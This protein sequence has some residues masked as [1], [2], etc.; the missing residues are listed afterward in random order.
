MTV[1]KVSAILGVITGL[2]VAGWVM[3]QDDQGF[4]ALLKDITQPAES[5]P[6]PEPPGP[7]RLPLGVRLDYR[8]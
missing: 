2:A 1:S 7:A 8:R 4:E 3:A 6:A 5:Q